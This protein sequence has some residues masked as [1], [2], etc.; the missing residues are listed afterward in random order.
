MV[1][2]MELGPNLQS[3]LKQLGL[4]KGLV[5]ATALTPKLSD[6]NFGNFNW[7]QL[8]ISVVLVSLFMYVCVCVYMCMCGGGVQNI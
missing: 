1:Q 6:S 8:L 7:I 3:R 4:V 2:G 5:K